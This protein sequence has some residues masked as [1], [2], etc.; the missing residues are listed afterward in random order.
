MAL[1]PRS[2]SKESL[3][4]SAVPHSSHLKFASYLVFSFS[5]R[6]EFHESKFQTRN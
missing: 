3:G 6:E 2:Q 4:Q 1:N 5:I